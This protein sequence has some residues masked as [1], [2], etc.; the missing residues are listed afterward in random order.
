MSDKMTPEEIVEYGRWVK[1][2]RERRSLTQRE[3]ATITGVSYGSIQTIEIGKARALGTRVKSKL[4]LYFA[5]KTSV[6]IGVLA[7][8]KNSGL[9]HFQGMFRKI[10]K[11]VVEGDFQARIESVAQALRISKEEAVV[12]ILNEDLRH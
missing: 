7:S 10:A 3:L 1:Q 2:E 11:V 5:G 12:R 4:D 8:T 6:A 9:E